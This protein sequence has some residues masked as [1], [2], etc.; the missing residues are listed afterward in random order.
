MFKYEVI[1][2]V[3]WSEGLTKNLQHRSKPC[4]EL[5]LRAASKQ[6][7]CKCALAC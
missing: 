5:L 2:R 1:G 3:E 7:S 6:A 4:S